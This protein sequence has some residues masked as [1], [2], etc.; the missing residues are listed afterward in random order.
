MSLKKNVRSEEKKKVEEGGMTEVTTIDQVGI[1]PRV[2]LLKSS[3]LAIISSLTM[4]EYQVVA[5]VRIHRIAEIALA[6]KVVEENMAM[7]VEEIVQDREGIN[8]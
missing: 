6:A 3:N 7:A 5:M 1:E 2:S 8:E 4:V